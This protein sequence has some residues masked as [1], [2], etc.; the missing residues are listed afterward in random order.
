MKSSL[1]QD[2]QKVGQIHSK[3]EGVNFHTGDSSLKELIG[4]LEQANRIASMTSLDDLLS[5]MLDLMIEISGGTNGT[6]YLLD[7]HAGELIF[8]V[9]RGNQDDLRLQGRRIKDN[10]GIVGF[11]VQIRQPVVIQ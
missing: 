3:T 2:F 11:S 8:A 5:Q 9:V 10:L 6:L 4:I 1:N 7:E